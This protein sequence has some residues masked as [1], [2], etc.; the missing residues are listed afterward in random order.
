M[1]VKLIWYQFGNTFENE[2][3]SIKKWNLIKN[4][5]QEKNIQ[6]MFMENILQH[7][8]VVCFQVYF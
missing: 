3:I 2:S 5:L 7:K 8:T 6:K 4:S 1:H